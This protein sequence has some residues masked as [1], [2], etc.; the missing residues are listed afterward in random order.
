MP[1]L[2]R[3]S[4]ARPLGVGDLCLTCNS[5]NSPRNNGLLVVIVQILRR[6]DGRLAAHPYRIRRIDGQP[7]P[8]LG[9]RGRPLH[10]NVFTLALTR[11]RHLRR[12]PPA[13][14]PIAEQS[15]LGR[16][17]A[18][19]PASNRERGLWRDLAPMRRLSD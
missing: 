1:P 7:F 15:Q 17:A 18:T 5:D 13:D 3:A 8:A 6:P 12:L 9:G 16:R 14:P 4:R 19:P 10:Q 2:N 11:A